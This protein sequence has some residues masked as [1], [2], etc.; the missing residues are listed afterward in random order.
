MLELLADGATSR[1]MAETL[2]FRDGTMRVYLHQLYRKLGVANRSE[3]AV[4]FVNRNRGDLAKAAPAREAKASGDLFGDAAIAEGLY[5]ALGVMSV[6]VG[7]CGLVWEVGLRMRGKTMDA[8]LEER[9]DRTRALWRALLRGDFAF[10]KHAYDEDLDRTRADPTNAVLLA[11][12]LR[13]GGYSAAAE[14]VSARIQ[15]RRKAGP[16]PSARETNLLRAVTT[17]IDGGD[18]TALSRLASDKASDPTKHVALCALFH[19]NRASRDHD[20]A[21]IAANALW[22]EAGSTRKQL[23]AMGEKPFAVAAKGETPPLKTTS[24]EKASSR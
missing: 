15:D 5:G 13:I 16:A 19:V 9:R 8:A 7:P 6:F 24:K 1:R 21:R 12:L 11:I 23:E 18:L 22:T 3:A 10:G 20:R 2:G 14:R 4:W 17:A